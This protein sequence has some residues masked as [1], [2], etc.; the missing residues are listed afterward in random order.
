LSIFLLTRSASTEAAR[1]SV[2]FLFFASEPLSSACPAISTISISGTSLKI[3]AMLR[4]SACEAGSI[5]AELVRKRISS[6]IL[7]SPR[8]TLTDRCGE[9]PQAVTRLLGSLASGQPSQ[10]CAPCPS[11]PC[12]AQRS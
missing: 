4:S 3:C 8:V 5:V 12:P 9:G 11:S 6:L 10:G 1:C 7:I 2:S